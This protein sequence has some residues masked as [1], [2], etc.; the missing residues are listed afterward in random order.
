MMEDYVFSGT[1]PENARSYVR[2]QADEELY[3]GLKAGKFCYVLNSRQ[4]GKSSLRVQV[5][6]RLK[7]EGI[8]CSAID[9]S[10]DDI[11][12]VTAEQWYANMLRSL[13]FDFDLKVDLGRWW[14][15]RNWL[16]P[17]R[18][19]REFIETVLLGQIC[20]KIV[21]FI[22]EIDSVLSL[23]FPT[24]DF[25]AFIRA[26]Y[27]QR[28][29]NPDYQRLTFCLLGV[30]TP[31]DLI[32]DKRRTPFNIGYAIEL[33][34]F[35]FEEAKLSLLKGLEKFKNPERVLKEILSWTGGQPFLTQKLCKL[36]VD[37]ENNYYPNVGEVVKKYIIENWE[38]NDEPEHLKTIR[39]RLLSNEQQ[40]SRLLGIYQQILQFGEISA[41]NSN[42]QM[43]LRLSVLVVN[44]Q[45]KLKVYN[46]I[47]EEIF[48]KKWVEK[49][50][51]N[52]RPYSQAIA[53]W[54]ASNRQD[55]SR[56]L[57][58][59]AL[60]EA[61]LW[62]VGKS[63]S[64]EDDDFLAASQQ[65]AWEQIQKDLEAERQAKKILA[66]AKQKAEKLL[67]AAKEGT[68][69]E[70]AGVQ[71][72]RM[73]EV[74]GREIQALLLAMEAG[75]AL[76][77]WQKNNTSIEDYT[78]TS[79]LIALQV[80]LEK[81]REKN[82]FTGHRGAVNSVCFSPDSK[83]LAT[84]SEDGTARLWDLSGKLITEFI[85]HKAWVSSVCFSPKGDKIAT[86]SEDTTARVW[87]LS[88]KQ[89]AE[90]RGHQG[91][92]LSVSFSPQGNAIA[93][94]GEDN[95]AKIW[96]LFGNIIL[97][98]KEHKSWILNVCFN[99][100]GD[101]LATASVDS[102][103]RLWDLNGKQLAQ[104]WGH[105]AWVW[106]VCFNADGNQI[107]TASGDGTARLWDLNGK[108]I[109][110]FR[111]HQ[112]TVVSVNFSRNGKYLATALSDGTA[113]LWNL[114]V[115]QIT[116]F[117]G[118]EA[119][120]LFVSFSP[121]GKLVASCS[122]DGTARLW[123]LQGNELLQLKN[124][125]GWVNSVSFSPD[126]NFLLT[127]GEDSLARLWD[128]SGNELVQFK[129]HS[130]WVISTCF[131][132][133]GDRI[134][135]ASADSHAWLWDLNGN[136]I[137]ELK[138]QKGK[139]SK[140]TFSPNGEYIATASDDCITRLWDIEGNLIR[141]FQGHQ[142]LVWSLSF[143][144]D[145]KTLVTASDDGSTRLWDLY[146]NSLTE[147][148]G[149]QGAVLGVSFNPNGDLIATSS[150]DCT[151][152]LWDLQGNQL[153]LFKGHQAPVWSVNFNPE[154]NILATASS[155]NTARLWQVG[156]LG[157]SLDELLSKGCEW[158]QDYLANHPQA[159]EKLGFC[160]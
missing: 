127:G 20:Q 65:A 81:I 74:E 95:T 144:P 70:R 63:L 14:R 3:Q 56:L 68:K 156:R 104:F 66:E 10:M 119:M 35:K 31:G 86:A 22:D 153:A 114:Y 97:E 145:S 158:L 79:P 52:M 124:H 5:M 149:H 110:E 61:L 11:Q 37:K 120:V 58:G 27:N 134:A 106:S 19:F 34:G 146:G 115:N 7:E 21:I 88:G 2:R 159:R 130:N 160:Q 102:T 147:F 91:R 143:S 128:L 12:Q 53:A 46:R 116:I 55:S 24:D 17:L 84:A 109:D 29:S 113:R 89:I 108:Q 45:G 93:T 136:K 60:Q 92:V 139:V 38:A 15:E 48:N 150:T 135:T 57:R 47:Y 32:A 121:D 132:P 98:I 62:K 25:F 101:A 107:A 137:G 103:A 9:I 36:V 18:R 99:P 51:A 8:A 126:G 33:S 87:D 39:D 75:I 96:D 76:K 154:G 155:D 26:C 72:L 111:G 82:Q 28:A 13:T 129:G 105:Q 85:G 90:M 59:Q 151:A 138:K 117:K 100:K 1:L 44:N 78:A 141:E 30:A 133:K 64:V 50:L 40:A 125:R 54:L 16:S 42:E 157:R 140:I 69:I 122:F 83:Y 131:S 77:N 49:T 43:Q 118:H 112:G 73:F 94:G 41:D 23:N 142:G 152:R 148:K 6:R 67:E 123:D 80:I 4:S 71:A